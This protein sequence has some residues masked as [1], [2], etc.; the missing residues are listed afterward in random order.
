MT[1]SNILNKIKLKKEEIDL[2]I[3][4]GKDKY[5]IFEGKEFKKY[6]RYNIYYSKRKI[7]KLIYKY[8]HIRK[9]N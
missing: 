4:I 3:I 5:I 1:K 8:M 9:D 7:K 6:R 2:Y